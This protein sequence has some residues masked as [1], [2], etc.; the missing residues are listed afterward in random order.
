MKPD[1]SFYEILKAAEE[2]YGDN[3]KS[4]DAACDEYNALCRG[5]VNM[6]ECPILTSMGYFNRPD[7]QS[8]MIPYDQAESDRQ[9]AAY[10][11]KPT[12]PKDAVGS[13]KPPLSTV[14]MGVM[15]EIGAA[16]LE[17]ACK[18]GRHNYRVAGVRSSVYFDAAMRHL[19]RWWEGEDIDP[20]SGM[21]HIT[22]C[23]A[24]LVVLR[25]AQKNGMV[26]WD[27]RPPKSDASWYE[28]AEDSAREILDKYPAESRKAPYTD[29][30]P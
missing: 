29:T 1:P 13:N 14:P 20:D 2:I 6:R 4:A 26:C 15:F 22:K 23:I 25:D 16:M 10:G 28:A 30:Q 8:T 18:Y 12:N 9:D 24:G 19:A 3:R 21:S 5:V 27:D 11:V 7:T 17:G